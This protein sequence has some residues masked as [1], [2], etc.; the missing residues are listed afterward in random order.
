MLALDATR[1]GG[2]REGQIE[3]GNAGGLDHESVYDAEFLQ[4]EADLVRV[5]LVSGVGKVLSAERIGPLRH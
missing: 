4:V 1:G 2:L 5:E 3:D